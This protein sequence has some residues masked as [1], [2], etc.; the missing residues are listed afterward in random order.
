MRRVTSLAITIAAVVGV[1]SCASIDVN[2]LPAPGNSFQGGYTLVMEFDNVLNL[3]A[4]AKVTLDGITVGIVTGVAIAANHVDVTTRIDPAVSVPSTIHASLQQATVLGDIYV[5]LSRPP[6]STPAPP[7]PPGSRLPVAQTTSPPQLEDTISHLAD[8]AGSGSLERIQNTIIGI[9]RI[10][11]PPADVRKIASQFSTDISDL[12]NNIDNVDLLLNGAA[13]TAQALHNRIPNLQTWFTTQGMHG[14]K[15][16]YDLYQY[17]GTAYPSVGTIYSGGF[18]IVP[19]LNSMADAAG[20]V[21]RSKWAFESEIHEWRKLFTDY[22]LPQDKYPAI[23]I[24]SIVAPD[25]RELSG[26]VHDVLRILGA[27]P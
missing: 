22:Y 16:A 20:A 24:T 7:L 4:R 6:E 8:F 1:S 2:A 14:W 17:T 18:W 3:P 21:Q 9:N 15:H 25:G 10:T 12:S 19:L 11:P 13:Q 5:A 27:M 26:N 23:N